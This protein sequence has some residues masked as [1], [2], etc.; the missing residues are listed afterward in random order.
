MQLNYNQSF[1]PAVAGGLIYPFSEN[2]I[3]TY[4]NP[5]EQIQWGKGLVIY[6][7]GGG[8][9]GGTPPSGLCRL[10]SSGGDAAN[11]I[12]VALRDTSSMLNYH[13]Q[14]SA[15]GVLRRGQVA[16]QVEQNVTDLSPV[17]V[18]YAA[19][20]QVQTLTFSG[21][22]VIENII[23]VNVDGF[24]VIYVGYISKSA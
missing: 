4:S 3:L 13:E 19:S 6:T 15:V 22:T 24:V 14:Y 18:R 8:G 11:F 10:P 1:Q 5:T 21:A 17:F 7:P 12:G 16:V 2:T 20:S 9:G 23:S